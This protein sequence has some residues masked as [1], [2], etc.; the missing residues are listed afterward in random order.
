MVQQQYLSSHR[1]Y[2]QMVTPAHEE[3]S[4]QLVVEETD[5][6]IL[7]SP[8]L[9][10]HSAGI[11]ELVH[12]LRGQIRAYCTLHPEFASSL[13]PVAV[14]PRAPVVIQRM[15]EAARV[16]HV[17]PMAAVAGTIAQA[18]A[19][20]FVAESAGDIIVENGGDIFLYSSR[21]RTVAL[22]GTPAAV[23]ASEPR[24]GLVIQA[25]QCPVA[26][27]A[28]SAIIGHS[29]SL[30]SGELVVAQSANASLADAAATALCNRVTSASDLSDMIQLAKTYEQHGLT[31]VFAQQ[32]T[33][34]A[35][36]GSLELVAL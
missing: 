19:A 35:A 7:G 31:G 36:W 29:L 6:H 23:A 15:A 32:G 25:E 27:C 28:S 30:G 18:V 2:R 16:C 34:I 13:V 10:T 20:A 11:A 1:A 9:S 33:H 21:K 3:Q 8:G 4:F 24:F 5:L 22:M 17:G 26:L 14:P 12:R